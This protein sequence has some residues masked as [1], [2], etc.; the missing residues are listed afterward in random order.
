[1]LL[2]IVQ[3]DE[4]L[5]RRQNKYLCKFCPNESRRVEPQTLSHKFNFQQ[6]S[7]SFTQTKLSLV[8]WN[9]SQGW[10]QIIAAEAPAGAL[11]GRHRAS[12][13]W[14]WHKS[15]AWEAAQTLRLCSRLRAL[16][17][18]TLSASGGGATPP[19]EGFLKQSQRNKMHIN[20]TCTLPGG[21]AWGSKLRRR[22]RSKRT[23]RD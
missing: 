12:L 8:P 3:T 13:R 5:C 22:K 23:L 7:I 10:A 14:H 18:K 9:L 20:R 16:S 2:W 17:F 11:G 15:V 1:M 21:R 19:Q 4:P 6:T